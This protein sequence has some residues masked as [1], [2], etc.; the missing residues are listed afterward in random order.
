MT[1]ILGLKILLHVIT[2]LANA[3]LCLESSHA[4]IGDNHIVWMAAS[5]SISEVLTAH[6]SPFTEEEV[7]RIQKTI[8]SRLKES[9]DEP[10][11]DVY[12]LGSFGDPHNYPGPFKRPTH[13]EQLAMSLYPRLCLVSHAKAAMSMLKNELL[14]SEKHKDHPLANYN[15]LQAKSEL[16]A[17][18]PQFACSSYPFDVALGNRTVL[19][20]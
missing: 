14:F 3:L 4:T 13:T 6:D 7:A 5:S 11:D 2:P 12:L 9:I 1:F 18:L 10:P 15:P 16:D 8:T 17:S 20:Y 19:G